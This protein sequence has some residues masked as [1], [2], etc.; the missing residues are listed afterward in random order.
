MTTIS[1]M[2]TMDK[3]LFKVDNNNFSISVIPHTFENTNLKKFK[4][5]S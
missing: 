3:T 5:R 2:T 1:K 4:E